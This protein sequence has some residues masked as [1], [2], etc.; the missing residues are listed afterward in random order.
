MPPFQPTKTE[1]YQNRRANCVPIDQAVAEVMPIAVGGRRATRTSL[2]AALAS[3]RI[4]DD[5]LEGAG[6]ISQRPPPQTPID[7]AKIWVP[8]EVAVFAGFNSS[9]AIPS[10]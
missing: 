5:S 3:V 6:G 2:R 7:H 9:D 10:R 8:T 4:S 1:L